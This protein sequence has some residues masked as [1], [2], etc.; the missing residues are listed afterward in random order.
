MNKSLILNIQI[1]WDILNPDRLISLKNHSK[2]YLIRRLRR[3]QNIKRFSLEIKKRLRRSSI[4]LDIHN[5]KDFSSVQFESDPK[6]VKKADFGVNLHN[7]IFAT[8]N[9]YYLV[10]KYFKENLRSP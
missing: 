5:S 9:I 6:G 2:P 8:V 3:F 1:D 7:P 10:R 4:D